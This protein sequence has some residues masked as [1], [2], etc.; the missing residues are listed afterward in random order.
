MPLFEKGHISWCKGLTKETDPRVKV[1]SDSLRKTIKKRGTWQKGLT[2]ETDE[3]LAKM[4]KK[5]SKT[6]MGHVVTDETKAKIS[7]KNSQILGSNEHKIKQSEMMKEM[8]KTS[9]Y[10][11]IR[12]EITLKRLNEGG[13]VMTEEKKEK[14]RQYHAEGRFDKLKRPPSTETK[15]KIG[16]KNKI[17]TTRLWQTEDFIRKQMI[18]RGVKPNK[19]ELYFQRFLDKYFPN[20]W[21]FVGDGQLIVGRKCPDFNNIVRH[22]RLIELFGDYFHKGEDPQD[23]ILYFR[24]YGYE[25]LVIWENEVYKKTEEELCEY[26]VNYWSK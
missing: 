13:F 14:M 10:K 6:R 11:K 18:G 21:K 17:N 12:S 15:A 25:T 23:R 24:E 20:E 26:I 22:G 19:L 7:A 1:R 4:G 2:K 3:R 16:K 8:W 5:V 9:S